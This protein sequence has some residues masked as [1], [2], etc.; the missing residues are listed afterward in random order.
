MKKYFSLLIASIITIFT[1]FVPVTNAATLASVTSKH[2]D[3][4]TKSLDITGTGKYMKLTCTYYGKTTAMASD[5]SC[6]LY[7]KT[8]PTTIELVVDLHVGGCY[9]SIT[10]NTDVWL[11]KEASYI[12]QADVSS[13]AD[14]KSSI[15]ATIQ[16]L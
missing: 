4:S 3:N 5:G 12:I 2:S 11:E 13:F 15:T 8:S 16:D 7:K 1:V 14:P 10:E 6:S 9:G